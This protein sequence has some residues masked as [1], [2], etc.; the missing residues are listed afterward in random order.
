MKLTFSRECSIILKKLLKTISSF[1]CSLLFAWMTWSSKSTSLKRKISW[2]MLVIK[3]HIFSFS[4]H[5]QQRC[6]GDL[7]GNGNGNHKTYARI[8]NHNSL[9]WQDN[10]F[11]SLR[12]QP[13]DQS[14]L[15]SWRHAARNKPSW[16]FTNATETAIRANEK[17]K[18]VIKAK[19]R[20]G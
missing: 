16:T 10:G 19:A 17:G 9:S 7:Q 12:S 6:H 15:D 8:G 18:A 3:V 2:K 5:D 11:S 14:K 13:N 4:H 20:R 1:Q